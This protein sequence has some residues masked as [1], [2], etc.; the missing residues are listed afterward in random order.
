MYEPILMTVPVLF[1]ELR[2][3]MQTDSIN[4]KDA[5]NVRRRRGRPPADHDGQVYQSLLAVARDSLRH[6]PYSRIEVRDLAAQA[7]TNAAMINY[8]FG[9]KEGLFLA[10]IDAMFDDIVARLE[11][12]SR[13]I[14]SEGPDPVRPLA[15]EMMAIYVSWNGVL[16]LFSADVALTERQARAAYRRKLAS[17]IFD[18]VSHYLSTAAAQ[19]MFRPDLDI[20]VAAVMVSGLMTF[21][22]HFSPLMNA[23]GNLT[24]EE[25]HRQRWR[26]YVERLLNGLLRAPL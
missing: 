19:R 10:L 11:R 23:A 4:A 2:I 20:E 3:E 24:W 1:P 8:Y 17:R 14:Q 5:D 21:P 16:T 26:D 15:N 13:A 7:G 25:G 9:G 6:Q 12:L 22:F 18:A